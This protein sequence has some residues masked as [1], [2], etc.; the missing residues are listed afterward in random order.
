MKETIDE[1]NSQGVFDYSEPTEIRRFC[2]YLLE[3]WHLMATNSPR[4][5]GYVA[6]KLPLN[7]IPGIFLLFPTVGMRVFSYFCF[8]LFYQTWVQTYE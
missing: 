6:S 2:A 1:V 7:E 5:D 8:V 4:K 3:E